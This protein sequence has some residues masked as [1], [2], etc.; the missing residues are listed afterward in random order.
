MEGENQL[1]G[2]VDTIA[3]LGSVIR[4]LVS[5]GDAMLTLDVLN[6]RGYGLPKVGEEVSLSF[7]PHACWVMKEAPPV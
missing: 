4:M 3:F 6:K 7:P 5:I 1:K 2:K